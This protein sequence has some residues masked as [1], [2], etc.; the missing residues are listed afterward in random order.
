MPAHISQIFRYPVKSMGGHTLNEANLGEQGIPG[1]RCWAVKDEE[2]GGIKGGKRFAALMNMQAR[3]AAEPDADNPSPHGTITLPDG[4]QVDTD[5]PAVNQRLSEAVG[6]PLSLWPLVPKEQLDHY[7]RTA[8]PGPEG[9][10]AWREVF[11]RTADEP[12]PDLSLFPP[13]L[14]TY[15]SPPG[16][17]FDAFPLLI[18]S[19]ASLDSMQAASQDAE[20]DVRRFRPNIVLQTDETG[21][22]EEAWA[23]ATATLGGATLKFEMACPRCVMTTHGFADLPKDPKIMRHLVKKNDGNLGIYASIVIPGRI[24]V[25]DELQVIL[26]T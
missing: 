6:N 15:E 2:R 19:Q 20:F 22:P 16:T 4:S 10:A 21:F 5:D 24:K 1:D 17:Y 13:E 9:E 26:S 23:G 12:L 25:G 18:L 14:M 7:L 11:A 3:L 8:N